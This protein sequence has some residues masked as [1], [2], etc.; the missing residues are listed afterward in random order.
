MKFKKVGFY[1]FNRDISSVN[2][3]NVSEGNPGIGGSEYMAVLI[4]SQLA[5]KNNKIN[6]TLFV[7]VAGIFPSGVDI[8][9]VSNIESAL[10]IASKE[11]YDLFVIDQKLLNWNNN[12]F[13]NVYGNLKIICWCHNFIT[14]SVMRKLS[15]SNR[16]KCVLFV[17]REQMDIYRDDVVFRKSEYIYNAVP[18]KKDFIANA[19]L[20]PF[21]TRPHTVAFLGS[22]V[23]NKNFHVLASL[24]P[25]ILARVPDAELYVI[26][27]GRVYSRN[28]L[29]GK[30]NI[31]EK[32]YE[33][34]FMQFLTDDYGRILPSVHFLG[35][36]DNQK[37]D[38]LKN[39]RVGCPNP[40]GDSETFCLSAVEMQ[41][42]GC[43]VAAME[44]PGYYDT[45]FNG[46]ISKDI[47][48]L[49]EDIITNLNCDSNE[50]YEDTISFID[51]NFSLEIIIND[52]EKLLLS[53]EC[54]IHPILPL[55]NSHYKHKWL[56]ELLRKVY[57]RYPF[58]YNFCPSLVA[59]RNI[60]N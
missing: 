47:N 35:N 13:K 54:K 3:S 4:A 30:Y 39:I 14:T 29:L 20:V 59:I 12:P 33:D 9:I 1:L 51:K 18:I 38:I 49:Y 16:V 22:L 8:K 50:K 17:G 26:G 10:S 46:H 19:K 45:F 21:Q 7:E 48:S 27:S 43:V 25:R 31:A 56:K 32:D 34:L 52:W 24:W 42:M 5:N 2:L 15:K 23:K 44:A 37:F 55:V 58:L 60:F 6:I 36:M 28:S 40:T 57:S 41:A 11:E 53:E